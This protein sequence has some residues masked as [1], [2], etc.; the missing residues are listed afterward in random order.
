M[1]QVIKLKQELQKREIAISIDKSKQ[2]VGLLSSFIFVGGNTA[3]RIDPLSASVPQLLLE[4]PTFIGQSSMSA[5]VLLDP[6]G[7]TNQDLVEATTDYS[8]VC[9]KNA[10]MLFTLF[11]QDVDSPS[12]YKDRWDEIEKNELNKGKVWSDHSDKT[13]NARAYAEEFIEAIDGKGIGYLYLVQDNDGQVD[14][15]QHAFIVMKADDDLYKLIEADTSPNNQTPMF[16][17][18]KKVYSRTEVVAKV[19]KNVEKYGPNASYTVSACKS[20]EEL[21]ADLEKSK[22]MVKKE[23]E[24]LAWVAAGVLLDSEDEDL[25]HYNSEYFTSQVLNE[26]KSKGRGHGYSEDSKIKRVIYSKTISEI[27]SKIT[28]TIDPADLYMVYDESNM[29]APPI[30]KQDSKGSAIYLTS[31]TLE[32]GE[33]VELGTG[34]ARVTSFEA[35][36]D[37]EN[38]VGLYEL[39]KD[40]DSLTRNLE[41]YKK[42]TLN[43]D[44][45]LLSLS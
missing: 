10:A 11:T 31:D 28:H 29:S 6:D 3:D 26:I 21:E 5:M 7:L 41:S 23:L 15:A 33:I 20:P 27:R 8:S 16:E 34:Y 19:K 2:A 9:S 13:T 42:W 36:V 35:K 40:I 39:V 25:S 44:K 30:T 32:E 1:G 17:S 4:P 14:P 12:G 24:V 18:M 38:H 43:K 37:E 22:E 45:F